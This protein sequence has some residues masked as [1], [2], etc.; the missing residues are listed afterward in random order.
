[1]ST[2]TIVNNNTITLINSPK[3]LEKAREHFDCYSLEGIPLENQGSKGSAGSYWEA[4]YMLGDYMISSDYLDNV[5][6]DISLAFFEDS[7]YYKVKYY[8][9]DL[10]KFGKNK[11]C[12]FIHNK[13]IINGTPSFEE[14][15][16]SPDQPL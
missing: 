12:G 2:T 7:G 4:R 13:C 10:F 5:I 8:S 9:G 1:M 11:G 16:T 14:F 6:S 3:V 15:C